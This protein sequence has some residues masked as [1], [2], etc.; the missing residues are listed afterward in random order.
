MECKY[1][2][3]GRR[4]WQYCELIDTLWNVNVR[5]LMRR[6]NALGINRYIMECKCI[7]LG[8]VS[9]KF[10]GINRYIMECKCAIF[11]NPL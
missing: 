4:E 6:Y 10:N 3:C 9:L 2:K 11:G 7:T 5:T 8:R 1:C